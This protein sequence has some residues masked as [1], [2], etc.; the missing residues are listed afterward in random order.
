MD[1]PQ[2]Q[3]R[4]M[5]IDLGDDARR[6]ERDPKDWRQEGRPALIITF[7]NGVESRVPTNKA[8]LHE[9]ARCVRALHDE[10]APFLPTVVA[11]E[12]SVRPTFWQRLLSEP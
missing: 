6:L 7:N 10:I 3:I 5:R 9:F 11:P 2:N 12:P 8:A 1:F 4:G